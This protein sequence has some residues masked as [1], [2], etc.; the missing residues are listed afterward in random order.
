MSFFRHLNKLV[1]NPINNSFHLNKYILLYLYLNKLLLDYGHLNLS[2]HFLKHCLYNLLLYSLFNY[3]RHFHHL[4]DH[5]RH[6]YQ[7]FNNFFDLHNLGNL[8]H[9]FNYLIHFHS[10]F[11]YP[12]YYLRY[13]HNFLLNAFI[14]FWNLQILGDNFLHLNNFR[15]PHNQGISQVYL[16][17][18]CIFYSFNNW[19]FNKLSYY[20]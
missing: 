1:N 2:F 16:L 7:L 3:L 17:N 6:H 8:H 14:G 12:I 15:F 10:H 11:L 4:L 5:S 9:L 18:N 19:L 20:F 13:L